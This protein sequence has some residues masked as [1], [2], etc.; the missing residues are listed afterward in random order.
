MAIEPKRIHINPETAIADL[1][2]AAD[3]APVVLENDGLLYRLT[4]AEPE[5]IWASYD[6]ARARRALARSAGAL[7][8]VDRDELLADI[9]A[10]REQDSHGRQT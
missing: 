7:I 5:D 6:P 8:G 9:Y 10:Q 2:R 1:L 4:Q 3:R